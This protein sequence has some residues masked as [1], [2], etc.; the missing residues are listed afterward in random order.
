[1]DKILHALVMAKEGIITFFAIIFAIPQILA[2]VV[3]ETVHGQDYFFDDWSVD[4]AYTS[5]Y[6]ATVEKDPNKDF[7]ILNITDVQ[8]NSCDAYG[9]KGELATG[10]INELVESTKPDLITMTGDNAWCTSAY[11]KLIKDVE[12]FNIPW[13]PVMGNH[14]GQGLISE[15]WAAYLLADAKNCL[16]RF[17]PKDMGYGNYVVNVTENGKIIHTLFMMD[18]HSDVEEDNINGATGEGYD[19]LWENQLEWYKWAVNGTTALAGHTVES[20]VYFHIPV[21]E[22]REAYATLMDEPTSFGEN[23]EGIW[24][25][26]HSNGFFDICKDLGSTKNI[27]FGHDHSNSGSVVLDGIRLTYGLKCG[28]GCYWEED[29]SGGTTITVDSNGK[30]KV[31]HVYSDLK[32]PKW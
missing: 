16:F 10:I 20:S 22:A 11:L 15:F 27:V 9:P 5:D 3:A 14:D 2:P 24:S 29:M 17:G 13:A 7:V 23:R 8:L 12:K 25:A 1:M 4:Q 19:H 18:T 30:A 32:E 26:E 21:F 28:S 6:A 31:Q